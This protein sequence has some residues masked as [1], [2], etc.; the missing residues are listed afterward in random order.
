MTVLTFTK[1]CVSN[2]YIDL[3]TVKMH[4]IDKITFQISFRNSALSFILPSLSHHESSPIASN[5]SLTEKRLS[6]WV[7]YFPS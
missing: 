2:T 3:R 4:L 5:Q 6:K 7:L 1:F